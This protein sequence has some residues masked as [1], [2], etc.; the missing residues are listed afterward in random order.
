MS[1]VATVLLPQRLK[2]LGAADPNALLASISTVTA[3]VSLVS[4]LVFGNFSDR[5]RSRLGRR[6]PWVVGGGLLGGIFMGVSGIVAV[7]LWPREGSAKDLQAPASSA[8]DLLMS[9]IP[10]I[11]GAADFWKAFIGRFTM[12]LS[13]QMINAYQLYIIQDH[14]K[15]SGQAL[16]A[17]QVAATVALTNSIIMVA[18]LVGG[19]ISGPISDLLRRRK[20]P[21]VF[22]SV[23]FAVGV[24][25]PWLMPTTTGMYMFALIA[26][27]GY[28]V[29][30]AVDQALNVD[31]LPNPEEAGKDLGILN[32]S[33][34]LGQMCG[35]LITA[36]VVSAQG[37]SY[38]LVFPISIAFAL[39][40]CISI[41][42]IKSVR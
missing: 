38:A 24:A 6:T 4:N 1:M 33:T 27:F 39:A 3:V 2:D 16:S 30:G 15:D 22:A 23:C 35:P 18:G 29:Y 28:A 8:K 34:T 25:M 14:L 42:M 32:M 7:L 11:H 13:Y 19:F 26:G 10:P 40:G 9:F 36:S 41:L 31:V 12:L 21:V 5:T 20:V 37:G 17:G